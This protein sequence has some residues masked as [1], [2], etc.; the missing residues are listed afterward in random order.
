MLLP[1]YRLSDIRA[2]FCVREVAAVLSAADL[3]EACA[4]AGLDKISG[5][6]K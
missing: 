3:D 4:K 2:R 6:L 1:G 5:R